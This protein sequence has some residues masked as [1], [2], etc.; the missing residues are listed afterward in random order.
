MPALLGEWQ[1]ASLHEHEFP[2]GLKARLKRVTLMDLVGRG[3][4]PDTLSSLVVETIQ[5]ERLPTEE[6]S[7]EEMAETVQVINL[8]CM[9]CFVEPQV[10]EEPTEESLGIY[11]IPWEIRTEVFSWANGAAEKLRPFR[12]EPAPAPET[13]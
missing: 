13:S 10:T 2:G 6:L 8:V 4:I 12:K 3:K 5:K 9:A 1:A 7:M 11:D